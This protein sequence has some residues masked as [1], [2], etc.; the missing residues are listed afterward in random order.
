MASLSSVPEMAGLDLK[1]TI[2]IRGAGVLRDSSPGKLP[3]PWARML[4]T[5][6]GWLE[7]CF[8][9][10]STLKAAYISITGVH[11]NIQI[12]ESLSNSG[13]LG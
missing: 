3:V 5:H 2:S 13:C 7:L 4:S 6:V 1:I 10:L 9:S 12:T 11:V 8:P